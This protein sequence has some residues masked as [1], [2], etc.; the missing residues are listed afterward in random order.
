MPHS[1]FGCHISLEFKWSTQQTRLACLQ[2]KKLT[3]EDKSPGDDAVDVTP[4]DS[5]AFPA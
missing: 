5:V 2:G 3:I 1:E 4:R